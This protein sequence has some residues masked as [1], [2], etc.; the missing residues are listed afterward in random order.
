MDHGRVM[1]RVTRAQI[2]A[3]VGRDWESRP[4][5]EDRALGEALA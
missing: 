3:F 1:Q 2:E 5:L 4:R